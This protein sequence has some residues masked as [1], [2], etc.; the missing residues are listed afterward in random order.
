MNHTHGAFGIRSGTRGI[1]G[2]IPAAVTGR[3]T[4]LFPDRVSASLCGILILSSGLTGFTPSPSVLIAKLKS[5]HEMFAAVLPCRSL[6]P[7]GHTMQ[8]SIINLYEESPEIY[9]P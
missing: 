3:R 8:L 9:G 4:R 2:L 6:I 7:I 1:H 5:F